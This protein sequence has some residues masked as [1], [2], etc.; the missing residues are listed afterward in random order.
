MNL[1]YWGLT[2]INVKKGDIILVDSPSFL[3]NA[4]AWFER[5]KSKDGKAR[6]GHSAIIIDNCGKVFESY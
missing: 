1:L 6:F 4:I 3:D 5:K 2:M